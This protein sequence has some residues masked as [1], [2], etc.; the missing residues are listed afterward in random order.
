M[1]VS[2]SAG[3]A[4]GAMPGQGKPPGT[5][6]HQPM[7]KACSYL[8]SSVFLIIVHEYSRLVPVVMAGGPLRMFL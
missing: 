5:K 6:E 4:P 7:V 2:K 1:S 8:K 3:E